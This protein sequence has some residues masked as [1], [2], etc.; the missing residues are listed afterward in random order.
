MKIATWNVNSI[1]ARIDHVVKF[2]KKDQSDIYLLQELK[3][4][5]DNFPSEKINDLKK[6]GDAITASLQTDFTNNKPLEI[7]FILG[8]VVNLA[9]QKGINC[10]YSTTLVASLDR[11]KK[12][13]VN[14]Q[15]P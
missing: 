1:N 7:D 15:N 8:Y 4:T 9:K 11:Y 5:N 14:E 12:G 2:I 13:T 3:C 6:E 10:P